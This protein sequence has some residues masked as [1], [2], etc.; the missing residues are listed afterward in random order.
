MKFIKLGLISAVLLFMV[1]TAI[2]LL[3]PS[4]VVVSRAININAPADSVYTNLN[5]L[6]R[7]K[8]WL[9]DSVAANATIT[10]NTAGRSASLRLDN[11]TISITE[12]SPKKINTIWQVGKAEQLPAV[13]EIITYDSSSTLTLH[14]EF[15]QKVK[16][17]PWEKFAAITSDKTLGSFMEG[18][19]ENLKKY[20][21]EQSR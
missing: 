20:V 7:W 19:M 12:T 18:S 13:F 14:W 8:Y 9:K 15:T 2:S 4:M 21:E 10:T 16:W 1:V 11:T 3:M 17:Y 5:D 6:S